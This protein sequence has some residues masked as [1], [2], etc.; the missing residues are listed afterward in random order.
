[1][2]P[3]LSSCTEVPATSRP[4]VILNA[5]V[6]IFAETA[7]ALSEISLSVLGMNGLMNVKLAENPVNCG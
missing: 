7:E 5:K 1:V 3:G 6:R 4:T 2:L